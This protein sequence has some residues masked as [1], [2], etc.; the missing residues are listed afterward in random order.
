[1][2][3]TVG[4]L[5]GRGILLLILGILMVI[6]TQI[7]TFTVAVLLS[8]LL[9]FFGIAQIAGGFSFSGKAGIAPAILGVLIIILGIIALFNTAAFTAFL[10]YFIAIAAIIHGIFEIVAAIVSKK[11][12]NRGLLIFTGI[13][14]VIFGVLVLLAACGAFGVITIAGN[15]VNVFGVAFVLTTVAGIMLGIVGLASLIEGIVLK[16][17]QKKAQ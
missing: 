12:I 3:L 4:A 5:V 6:F 15:A 9:I 13:I 10:V 17:S 2:N 8:I 11:E 16:I 1:M 7:S 14:S